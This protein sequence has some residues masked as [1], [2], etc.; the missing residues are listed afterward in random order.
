MAVSLG[1]TA[2][3]VASSDIIKDPRARLWISA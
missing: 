2:D 3:P 1:V